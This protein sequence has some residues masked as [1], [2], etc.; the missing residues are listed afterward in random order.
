MAIIVRAK[1]GRAKACSIIHGS[2]VIDEFSQARC[3]AS[4]LRQS[5]TRSSAIGR[6]DAIFRPMIDNP[7]RRSASR[8]VSFEYR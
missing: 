7:A 1:V 2:P 3:L 4:S 5:Q 8:L 6:K